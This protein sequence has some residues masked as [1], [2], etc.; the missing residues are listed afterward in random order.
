MNRLHSFA[1]AGVLAVAAGLLPGC[2]ATTATVSGEVTYDGKPVEDGYIT[3]T[4][5]TA[6]KRRRRSDQQR[7]LH[8]DRTAAGTEGGQ[9]NRRQEGEL[10]FDQ[11]GDETP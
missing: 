3:F 11:R 8:R 1:V 5:A 9:G 10:R 6:R 7:P 4:P 2:G